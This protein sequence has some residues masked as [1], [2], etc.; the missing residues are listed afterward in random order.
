MLTIASVMTL[1]SSCFWACVRPVHI[2]TRTMGMGSSLEEYGTDLKL[3]CLLR[4]V[5]QDG[6]HRLKRLRL[7]TYSPTRSYYRATPCHWP[8]TSLRNAR[9]GFR[10]STWWAEATG[11]AAA[12]S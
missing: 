8:P 12:P 2:S 10:A 5:K 11:W 7:L 9:C 1:V 4:L 6:Q 3:V